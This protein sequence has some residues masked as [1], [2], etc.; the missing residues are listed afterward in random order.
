MKVTVT[1]TGFAPGVG[2]TTFKFGSALATGV[3]CSAYTKCVATS[4][5]HAAGVVEVK[6]NVNKVASPK[7]PPADQF[8]YS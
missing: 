1:G 7:D 8:T 2:T 5:K 6:A 4:P 3:E